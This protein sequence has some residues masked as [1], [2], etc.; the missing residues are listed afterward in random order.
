VSSFGL[1]FVDGKARLTRR[2][3]AELTIAIATHNGENF[4]ARTVA[5]ALE[6]GARV[7]VTDD[8][9]T[10]GTASILKMFSPRLELFLQPQTRGMAA[11][12]QLLLDVCTTPLILMLDQDDL[13]VSKRLC[14]LRVSPGEVSV[15]N[16][17]VI[18][19]RGNRIRPIYRCPP[20]QLAT[21][22]VYRGLQIGNFI[23]SPSQV[24]IPVGRAREV[25]GYMDEVNAAENGGDRAFWLR[26]ASAGMPFQLHMRPSMAYRVDD[27]NAGDQR[28]RD[29][30]GEQ[31]LGRSCP[32]P[33]FRDRRLRIAW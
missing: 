16:G 1:G 12:K 15:M 10:D 29:A 32:A 33:P 28:D 3:S 25:G 24:I 27:A 19:G 17:W 4:V 20:L 5:S 18:D 8:G 14:G 30:H 31:A 22:G 26:L 13:V 9:S 21:R 6:T 2:R 11:Q 23:R 7:V